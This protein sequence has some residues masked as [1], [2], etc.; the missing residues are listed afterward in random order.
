[1]HKEDAGT[2][3]RPCDARAWPTPVEKVD[4]VAG[5]EDDDE[6]LG[7]GGLVGSGHGDRERAIHHRL[8]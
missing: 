6:P 5:L 8:G 7:L 2:V 4:S 1:M 3:S